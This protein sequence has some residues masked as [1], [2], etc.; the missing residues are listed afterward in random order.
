VEIDTGSIIAAEIERK[1]GR[2]VTRRMLPVQR[3]LHLQYLLGRARAVTYQAERKAHNMDCDLDE[4][5]EFVEKAAD[6]I[7]KASECLDEQAAQL[8]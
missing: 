2:E 4:V 7:L 1:E 5:G 6:A 3:R 8:R